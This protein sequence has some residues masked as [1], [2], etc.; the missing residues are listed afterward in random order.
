MLK[1]RIRVLPLQPQWHLASLRVMGEKHRVV[2]GVAAR[3]AAAVGI[4]ALQPH[5]HKPLQL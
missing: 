4:E 1:G 2:L 3:D 5:K